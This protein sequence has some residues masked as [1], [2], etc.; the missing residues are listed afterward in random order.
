MIEAV[1]LLLL[2]PIMAAAAAASFTVERRG[3]GS[4]GSTAVGGDGKRGTGVASVDA[5]LA[6]WGMADS[7][8]VL[9]VS[10]TNRRYHR[11]AHADLLR[12]LFADVAVHSALVAIASRFPNT[13]GLRKVVHTRVPCTLASTH[14]FD[15]LA[16][17]YVIPGSYEVDEEEAYSGEDD[18]GT[19]VVRATGHISKCFDERVA[20]I[21]CSDLLRVFVIKNMLATSHGRSKPGR[22]EF[23]YRLFSHMVVGGTVNQYEDE[24]EPYVDAAAALYKSL[25]RAQKR[26]ADADFHER[27]GDVEQEERLRK[28]RFVEG[29]GG[30][31]G[32]ALDE[33]DEAE[34]REAAMVEIISDVY[35]VSAFE[36]TDENDFSNHEY[37]IL[38][39]CP[40][41]PISFDP[42]RTCALSHVV[43]SDQ[44]QCRCIL[45]LSLS[46]VC[47]K[48]LQTN[49]DNDTARIFRTAFLLCHCR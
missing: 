48:Y 15:A 7:C 30:R 22:G 42:L 45:S 39:T 12:D 25:L 10:Y 37:G 36:T 5:R 46:F 1:C 27:N 18:G 43:V 20:G 24:L 28:M 31:V 49:G 38:F 17:T 16:R 40:I 29:E 26:D 11:L 4:E 35:S 23:L 8:A 44:Y 33:E 6:K 2:H 47:P 32:D 9:R 13:A 21:T 34:A 3:D 41:D 19:P 14:I